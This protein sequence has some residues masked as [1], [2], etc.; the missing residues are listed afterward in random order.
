MKNRL[1]PKQ[2]IRIEKSLSS[3]LGID[4]GIDLQCAWGGSGIKTFF[5]LLCGNKCFARQRYKLCFVCANFQNVFLLFQ[6]LV[7]QIRNVFQGDFT[8]RVQITVNQVGDVFHRDG[9]LV[10][11]P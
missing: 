11:C 9:F 2:T 8:I 1:S 10:G 7:N 6:E 5:L 4:Y 3:N